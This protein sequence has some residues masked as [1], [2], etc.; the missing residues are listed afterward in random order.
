MEI[1]ILC[2]IRL[3]FAHNIALLHRTEANYPLPFLEYDDFGI[4][5]IL[6]VFAH[7]NVAFVAGDSEAAA[8]VCFECL[9]YTK[10]LVV[11]G[12]NLDRI[13]IGMIVNSSKLDCRG[14]RLRGC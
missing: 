1:I 13:S 9:V 2:I 14:T 4:G 6:A 7:E 10:I 12:E 11:A 5:T 3:L 8:F